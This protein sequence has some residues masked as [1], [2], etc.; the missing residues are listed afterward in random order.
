MAVVSG[1]GA[2]GST[3]ASLS[4]VHLLLAIACW[5]ALYRIFSVV[6]RST[7]RAYP[8][9]V[10]LL[11][12]GGG[13]E[14]LAAVANEKQEERDRLV[15]KLLH[16]G[17]SYAVSLAHAVVVTLRGF[18]LKNHRARP[19]EVIVIASHRHLNAEQSDPMDGWNPHNRHHPSLSRRDDEQTRRSSQP[20][21]PLPFCGRWS[22]AWS[23]G[24]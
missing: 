23:P 24:L 8:T 18:G 5:E 12:G 22:L 3:S 4:P 11:D 13:G 21:P 17:A 15:G 7:Y 19:K 20:P 16:R 1:G 10:V 2:V 14:Q 9:E 6:I